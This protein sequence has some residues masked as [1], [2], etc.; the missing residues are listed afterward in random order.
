MFFLGGF[1]EGYAKN[2]W[3]N[4]GAMQSV[5]GNKFSRLSIVYKCLHSLLDHIV[6]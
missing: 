6:L 3:I 2:Q 4:H 1:L 5:L